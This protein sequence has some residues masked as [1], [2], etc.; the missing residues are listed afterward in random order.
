MET[1]E[2]ASNVKT[3]K[4]LQS[5]MEKGL[6]KHEDAQGLVPVILMLEGRGMM[7]DV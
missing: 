5:L 1:V 7:E 4:G 3:Q 6:E 2:L